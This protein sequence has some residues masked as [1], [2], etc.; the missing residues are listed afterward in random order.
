M[1]P[2]ISL[3]YG[4]ITKDTRINAGLEKSHRVDALCI[5]GHP[6]AKTSDEWFMQK[7][8]R[9]HN[10]QIH[11]CTIVKG[12]TRKLNQASKYVFGYQLFD[13]VR[14]N[15]TDCFIFGRRSNGS[16]DIRLL[17]GTK[18]HAGIS[19]KKLIP[20]EKRRTLLTERR[21]AIPT[22]T[23]AADFLA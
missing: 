6:T 20:L 12:G 13:K 2:D 8:V 7:K 1:Y 17:D 10:R 14:Y 22:A 23:K 15:N 3:T 19:F 16:F 18:V 21:K 9:C 5:A 11:K 4:Y